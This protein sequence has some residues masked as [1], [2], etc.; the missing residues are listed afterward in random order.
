[1]TEWRAH[2]EQAVAEGELSL[3]LTARGR[4]GATE[5]QRR[6]LE[7]LAFRVGVITSAA[8]TR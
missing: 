3:Q 2:R 8:N 4:D 7:Q 1:M 5:L 6:L